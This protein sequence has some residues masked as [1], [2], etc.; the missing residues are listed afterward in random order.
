MQRRQFIRSISNVAMVSA[1]PISSF[2]KSLN[3]INLQN[4]FGAKF[5][6]SDFS[7]DLSKSSTQT[8]TV[9]CNGKEVKIHAVQ[10][11]SVAVKRSHLTNRTAHFL[12]PLKISLDKHFTEFMPIW[13]WVIEHPEGVIVIDTGE[14]AQ[15]MNPDYFKPV[16]KLVSKYSQRNLKFKVRKENEIGFQLNQLGI[17]NEDIKNVVL[18]HLHLD[19]TDGIKDFSKVEIILNE[20]EFKKPS[21]HFPELLPSWFKP[22]TVQYKNN[23]MEIFQQAYPIT[24]AEDLLLIP[25]NGHTKNHASVLFKTDDFDIL[26]AGDV[27]YNQKQLLEKDLPGINVNYKQSRKTYENILNYA[28]QNK[29]IFLPSH[30]MDAARRLNARQFLLEGD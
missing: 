24:Q 23:F 2:E 10:T 5:S 27:C 15:V 29:L 6:H 14:N 28:G 1:L 21:G 11:G 8:S 16:G 13:V 7:N 9:T 26:F 3:G 30:D 17:K 22:K 12:T 25:T 4:W 19:H 20:D 18:T